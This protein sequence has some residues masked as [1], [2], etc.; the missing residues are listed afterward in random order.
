MIDFE[1]I[2]FA[3]WHLKRLHM[4]DVII[5]TW[6]FKMVSWMR[7]LTC[8]IYLLLS[9]MCLIN[10]V[11][12]TPT[13]SWEIYMDTCKSLLM[14]LEETL[15]DFA[16]KRVIFLHLGSLTCLLMVCTMNEMGYVEAHKPSTWKELLHKPDHMKN[17]F[18]ADPKQEILYTF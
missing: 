6:T 15:E 10:R 14:I 17:Y 12:M 13:W 4:I 18:K 8:K 2:H 11:V 5:M 16:S 3:S 1:K 9:F 7:S